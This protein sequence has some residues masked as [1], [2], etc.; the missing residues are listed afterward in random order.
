MKKIMGVC[1]GLSIAANSLMAWAYPDSYGSYP[2]S[3]SRHYPSSYSDGCPQD[4]GQMFRKSTP[5][6]TMPTAT[7]TPYQEQ[8]QSSGKSLEQQYDNLI[9][10]FTKDQC[11]FCRY[12]MPIM[13]QVEMKF[14]KDIK[15]LYVD[16][17][18]N[19][20]YPSQYGFSTVPH[21]VY[22]KDGKKLDAH[23]SGNKTMTA[24]QVEDKIGSFFGDDLPKN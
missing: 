10:M 8:P 17:A 22:F 7:R 5:P 21:I 9:V 4:S 18:Q 20:Q 16:I 1:I 14:G 12:M 19:P 24:A 13:K 15:F 23:G 11:G 2:Y 3:G 6:Q